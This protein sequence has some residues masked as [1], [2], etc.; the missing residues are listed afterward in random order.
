MGYYIISPRVNSASEKHKL[1]N[2]SYFIS[3][4]FGQWKRLDACILRLLVSSL[5][6]VPL[7]AASVPWKVIYHPTTIPSSQWSLS[8]AS[9]HRTETPFALCSTAKK[10]GVRRE[11]EFVIFLPEVKEQMISIKNSHR[12]S[13]GLL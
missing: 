2:I 5:V 6:A 4:T 8:S 13:V 1:F 3:E 7:G 12:N 9:L 10:K 11:V